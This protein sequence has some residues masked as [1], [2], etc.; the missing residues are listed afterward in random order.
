MNDGGPAFPRTCGQTD[1]EAGIHVGES[2]EAQDGMSLR[3]WY[4]GKALVGILSNESTVRLTNEA[5]RRDFSQNEWANK[6]LRC[7]ALHAFKLADAM[8]EAEA[9]LDAAKEGE[10]SIT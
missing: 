6:L 1:G 3:Q 9:I 10:K 4:A 8:L 2:A 7:N 5:V